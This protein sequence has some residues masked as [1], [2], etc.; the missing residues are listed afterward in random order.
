MKKLIY[1][2]GM[3]IIFSM[4]FWSCQNEELLTGQEDGQVLKSAVN[5]G[6][7]IEKWSDSKTN[8]LASTNDDLYVEAF[9]DNSNLY[10][11]VYRLKNTF[12]R[13]ENLV[14]KQN[15]TIIYGPWS[16][17]V[18]AGK[19]QEI[20]I[21]AVKINLP[22]DKCDKLTI[23]LTAKGVG[24]G[25]G[26][27][28]SELE[29][30]LREIATITTISSSVASPVCKG[31]KVT[32]TAEV[33]AAEVISGGELILLEGRELITTGPAN[34]PLEYNYEASDKPRTFTVVYYGS[35]G[36]CSSEDNITIDTKD[37]SLPG[38]DDTCEESF[39]YSLN[40]DGSYTF[41]Y[42]PAEDFVNANVVFTFAQGVTV[43]G[44]LNDWSKNGVTRQKTMNLN[45]CETY[46]WTV[47]LA[48]DCKGQTKKSNVWTD[49]K[50]VPQ[51]AT[52]ED[53]AYSKKESPDNI[54]MSCN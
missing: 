54:E 32:L 50:V 42:V 47:T 24:N 7:C 27:V 40:N 43:S 35:S 36:Y 12:T 30:S 13:V 18:G 9:N 53:S 5:C 22:W 45:A 21:P 15:G 2:F 31:E 1:T 37:C 26:K 51:D 6:D 48:P 28:I 33:S 19:V 16:S 10:L 8:I 14:V 20:I 34:E 39:T 11:R 44:D 29:Y 4:V 49:F 17:P 25:G 38:E 46:S 23:S 52:L 3:M 41:N